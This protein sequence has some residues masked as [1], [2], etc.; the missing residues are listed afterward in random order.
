MKWTRL[1]QKQEQ[2]FHEHKYQEG[3][4]HGDIYKDHLLT[5]GNLRKLNS[6]NQNK[7]E[8]DSDK[9]PMLC[10]WNLSICRLDFS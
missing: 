3:G 4:F 5:L 10:C 9:E 1:E 7:N 8:G 6:S 2:T